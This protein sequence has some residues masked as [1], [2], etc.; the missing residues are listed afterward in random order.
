MAYLPLQTAGLLPLAPLGPRV[1]AHQQ[2]RRR[3]AGERPYQLTDEEEKSLLRQAGEGMIGG[4]AAIGNLFDIPGSMV[5]DVLAWQNPLDQLLSPFS[6]RN[7]VTGRE[8][9][10][11][12]GWIGRNKVGKLDWGD[13]GG[14]GIEV[15]FDPLTYLLPGLTKSGQIAGKLGL[16]A[17]APRLVGRRLGKRIGPRVAKMEGGLEELLKAIPTEGGQRL[18][19]YKQA[20][21]AAK[22]QGTTLRKLLRPAA[23][24]AERL[25]GFRALGIPFTRARKVIGTGPVAMGYAKAMDVAGRAVKYSPPMRFARALYSAPTQGEVGKAAQEVAEM[26]WAFRPE[27]EAAGK[28]AVAKADPYIDEYYKLY[29]Q[30]HA[31]RA[32][33]L[34][35]PKVPPPADVGY[36][37]GDVVFAKDT[38]RYGYVQRIQPNQ[39]KV[40]F[41]NPKSGQVEI[42]TIKHAKSN[43]TRAAAQGTSEAEAFS[44]GVVR[45]VENRI[46]QYT[47][48]LGGPGTAGRAARA[49]GEIMPGAPAPSPALAAITE[50]AADRMKLANQA[51]GQ[52]VRRKGAK[53]GWIEDYPGSSFMP[54]HAIPPSKRAARRELL[55]TRGGRYFPSQTSSTLSRAPATQTIPD[56]I[57][58]DMLTDPAARAGHYITKENPISRAQAEQLAALHIQRT[59]GRELGRNIRTAEGIPDPATHA[60]MLVK[61]IGEHGQQYSRPG[62]RMFTEDAPREFIRYQ[63]EMHK[64]NKSLDASQDFF[65]DN[66]VRSGTAEDG[67]LLGEA[68]E[69][70]GLDPETGVAEFARRAG[71]KSVD[72][73]SQWRVPDE[74]TQAV[75]GL[76]KI[77][78]SPEWA[79]ALGDMVDVLT[80]WFKRHVTLPFAIPPFSAFAVRNLGTGQ[81]NIA[82]SGAIETFGDLG[83]YLSR[84]IESLW[85]LDPKLAEEV[86]IRNVISKHHAFQGVETSDLLGFGVGPGVRPSSPVA[87]RQTLTDVQRHIAENPL[88][89]EGGE[90]LAGWLGKERAARVGPAAERVLR[91]M[92]VADEALIST[93]AKFNQWVEYLNRVPFYIYL[94]KDKGYSAGAAKKLVDLLQFD[95]SRAAYTPFEWGTMRRLFPFYRFTKG[96][97]GLTLKTLVE[98]PGGVMAQ[99]I[100]AT[101]QGRAGEAGLPEYIRQT[102]AIPIPGGPPGGD[103]YL[104]GFGFGHE[105]TLAFLGAGTRGFGLEALSRANPLVKGPLEWFTNQ[106]FF[107]RGPSGGRPL[108]DLDPTLG[109]LLAN[110]QG[111]ER[112]VQTSPAL[113]A[114]L[115][116]LPTTR[117]MT[118]ARKLSDPRK[119][120]WAQAIN[121]ATGARISDVSPGARESV[122][123]ESVQELMKAMPGSRKYE[124]WYFSKDE[125]AAMPPEQRTAALRLQALIG[126][127]RKR[128]IERAKAKG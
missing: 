42:R 125:L 113:E 104:A 31:D 6:A 38:Q 96:M 115:G 107:Q 127:L 65:M 7:R 74:I 108:E 22:T 89:G 20:A 81:L 79:Q 35:N 10:E 14:F 124:K 48:Q 32:K 44:L 71:N 128:Q 102:A 94:R 106:T 67:R 78:E 75:R 49:F 123:R 100:R 24:E 34:V 56:K 2:R 57:V 62:A 64:L 111:K 15:A 55:R 43:L 91:P 68:F 11:K 17:K 112:P 30:T 45:D 63:R 52:E 9:G 109:R 90:N 93:G 50:Q 99:T 51:I 119:Q 54:R 40:W 28:T 95:Y 105:D 87:F 8:L 37:V 114:L 103:R 4:V 5:R 3:S 13:V 120:L 23:G 72:E 39:T 98:R 126:Q 101:R 29:E 83:K 92:R 88:F 69:A 122:I 97:A 46:L 76:F 53:M 85:P 80:T 21:K 41:K 61:W 59:Y 58:T 116:N 117:Y 19:A 86:G 110:L 26:E 36:G 66:V 12:W 77:N 16:L 25:G 121:Q 18:G 70:A 33:N 118:T 27:A 82:S 73:V 1:A 47:G 60:Q 84:I